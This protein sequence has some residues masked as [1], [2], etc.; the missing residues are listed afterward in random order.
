MKAKKVIL[1]FD[2]GKCLQIFQNIRD[3]SILLGE[4]AQWLKMYQNLGTKGE[5]LLKPRLCLKWIE[6]YIVSR[7]E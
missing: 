4:G 2:L 1:I 6:F 7:A 5:F 3:G